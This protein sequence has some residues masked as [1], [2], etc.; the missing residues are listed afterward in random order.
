MHLGVKHVLKPIQDSA[1]KSVVF[2]VVKKKKELSPINPK[3]WMALFQEGKDDVSTTRA[4]LVGE[5]Q[6]AV[7]EQFKEYIY[8]GS[9][10]VPIG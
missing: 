10:P 8:I 4:F 1:I 9:V 7:Q 6:V 3:P 5:I 2:P